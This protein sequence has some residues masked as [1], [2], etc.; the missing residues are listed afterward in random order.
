MSAESQKK[1]NS[2]ELLIAN[3][4]QPAIAFPKQLRYTQIFYNKLSGFENV[5]HQ[6]GKRYN[7]ILVWR[8]ILPLLIQAGIIIAVPASAIHT[9]LTGKTIILQTAD[10]VV[11]KGRYKDGFVS[12]NLETYYIPEEQISE[13][14]KNLSRQQQGV[15]GVKQPIAIEAKV[16]HQGKPVPISIWVG[17]RNYRF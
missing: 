7:P 12:Y 13:V 5:P 17:D 4:P 3:T 10:Q 6:I 16:D 9:Y 11:L 15:V 8:F 2:H 1:L 14:N